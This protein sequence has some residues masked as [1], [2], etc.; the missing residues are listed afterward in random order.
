MSI[1]RARIRAVD[2]VDLAIGPGERVALVGQN[3][4]GKSTLVKHLNGL[5]RP[6]SGRVLIDGDD[7]AS[8]TVAALARHVGSASRTRTG[9]SSRGASGRRSASARATWACPAPTSDRP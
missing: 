3:G 7:A 5:L 2:G 1:P 8:R 4:S 6:T 9:R